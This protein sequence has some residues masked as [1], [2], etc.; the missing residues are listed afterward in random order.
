MKFSYFCFTFLLSI[1]FSGCFFTTKSYDSISKSYDFSNPKILNLTKSLSEISG[2][3]YYKNAIYTH[4]DEEGIVFIVNPKSGEISEKIKFGKKGDYEGI[5]IVNN[6]VY[7]IKNN[8][9]ISFFELQKEKLTTL[10]NK[11]NSHNNIEGLTYYKPTNELLIA[12]KGEPLNKSKN[13]KAIYSFN[14]KNEK[15]NKQP[16]LEVKLKKLEKHIKKQF[17]HSSKKELKKQIKRSLNFSPS[18]IAIHPKTKDF[19]II[20]AQ[21][22][23]LV[24][25][26]AKKEIKEIIF[27]NTNHLPQP[28]GICFDNKEN[29]YISTETKNSVG[30]IYKYLH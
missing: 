3:A 24:I 15:L 29:L 20:S 10:T 28:E 14:L 23:L 30:K 9:D 17:K 21:G 5:E 2:L 16:F 12:C 11:L 6:T 27:L 22:S 26:N 1:V 19:Y 4:N 18:G 8:G 25:F 13:T 7:V